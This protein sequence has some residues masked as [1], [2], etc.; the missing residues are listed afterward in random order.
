MAAK[1]GRIL[2]GLVAAL[3]LSGCML[4]DRY[5][6]RQHDRCRSQCAPAYYPPNGCAPAQSGYPQPVQPVAAGTSYSQPPYCP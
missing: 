6:D 5:C 1:V 2:A 3:S 4:C